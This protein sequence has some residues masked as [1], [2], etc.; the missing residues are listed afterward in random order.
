LD[1]EEE[2]ARLLLVCGA[3]YAKERVDVC[4]VIVNALESVCFVV[5]FGQAMA[6]TVD[7]PKD[8]GH[9]E[10]EVEN[11][12]QEKEQHCLCKVAKDANHG[13]SHACE[14]AEGVAHEYL[15]WE[16]VVLNESECHHDEGDNDGERE[17]VL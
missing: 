9:G 7:D 8:L 5:E 12:W 1:H 2:V 10:H 15:G 4:E 3:K 11:L 6:G 16:F 13:E 14:V 17:D